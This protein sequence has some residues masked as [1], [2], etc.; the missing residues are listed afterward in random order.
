MLAGDRAREWALSRGLPAAATPAEAAGWHVTDKAQQQWRKYRRI[1]DGS[2]STSRDASPSPATSTEQQPASSPSEGRAAQAQHAAKRAKRAG[3]SSG[4][5]EE[6]EAQRQ[7]QQP[8]A[9]PSCDGAAAAA[10]AEGDAADDSSLGCL[11]DTVGCVVLAADGSVAA[12]VSSGGIA[13]KTEGRVGEAAVYGAGCWAQQEAAQQEQQQAEQQQRRPPGPSL[14]C[15]V[16]GVGERVVRHL[17][18]RELC[19]TAPAVLA[20]DGAAAGDSSEEDAG[21]DASLAQ[22]AEQLLQRTILRG[23]P[24]R[25][26]GL[27]CLQAL[28]LDGGGGSEAAQQQQQQGRPRAWAV[29]VA[30]AHTAQSMAFGHMR[31]VPD[32][33]SGTGGGGRHSPA[34]PT[35]LIL[36]RQAGCSGQPAPQVQTYVAGLTLHL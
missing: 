33:T 36:R 30:V 34:A 20:A 28:P 10:A 12:G 8:A 24:P 1:V 21:G 5:R 11:Y 4:P 25:E 23:A 31:C 13:L 19:S 6:P 7:R 3:G 9:L 14:A 26:A 2:S 27:L 15:S 29:E 22:A 18:A 32:S 16:T 17:L 35:V